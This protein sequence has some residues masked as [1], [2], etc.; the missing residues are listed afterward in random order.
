MNWILKIQGFL[1]SGKKKHEN[2]FII[3]LIALFLTFSIGY[4]IV[5][6]DSTIDPNASTLDIQ[7][8]YQQVASQ[9]TAETKD[10]SPNAQ[11]TQYTAITSLLIS[12]IATTGSSRIFTD[13]P[14]IKGNGL[15]SFVNDG[16]IAMIQNQPSVNIPKYMAQQWVP[17]QQ[18]NTS[19]Y[20]ATD[21]YSHLTEIGIDTLWNKT[22]LIAYVL[23][24][25]VL[26]V[27]GFMIMFRQKIGGQTAITIFNAIPNVIIGLVLVAFSFAI[28]GLILNISVLATNVIAGVLGVGTNAIKVD[29]P[30][31]LFSL[32]MQPSYWTALGT[33]GSLGNPMLSV[34]VGIATLGISGGIQAIAILVILLISLVAILYVS[35]RVY[36]VLLQAYLSI[37]ID[38]ILAPIMI[39][40]GSIPGQ[41]G[42]RSEVFKRVFKN[43]M[44][45]PG[46][47]L[48]I[49]LGSFVLSNQ[50]NI[51][52]PY[53]LTTGNWANA[54]SSQGAI[55]MFLRIVISIGLF[56]LAAEVPTML[57]DFIALNGGKNVG[58]ALGNAKKSLSK[59]PLVGSVFN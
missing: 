42:M 22:S 44:I 14:N 59:I 16:I 34:I 6:A 12:G 52:F 15:I 47:F 53:G 40:F 35:I 50:I 39:A 5:R 48:F 3:S 10:S 43:A 30:F 54:G 7:G 36:F 25:I 32:L 1:N 57:N 56:Y 33:F 21:G 28:I 9:C 26:I 8:L 19:L 38:V 37:L 29:S 27:A 18:S 41:E 13:D 49:N 58:E 46:V 17:G 23:F 24:V 31:S 11:C 55:G 20:A 45:F 2:V 51:Q 4:G